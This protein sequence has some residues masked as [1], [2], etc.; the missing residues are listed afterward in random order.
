MG[1]GCFASILQHGLIFKATYRSNSIF[2]YGLRIRLKGFKELK[3]S[4]IKSRD[5]I[6]V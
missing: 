5:N 2:D 1:I 3:S 4:Q 6:F